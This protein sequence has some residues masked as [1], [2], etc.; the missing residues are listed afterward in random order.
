MSITDD[1]LDDLIRGFMTEYGVSESTAILAASLAGTIALFEGE[2]P[3][4]REFTRAVALAAQQGE[5]WAKEFWQAALAKN[6]PGYRDT[7]QRALA[8]GRNPV[9]ELEQEHGLSAEGAAEAMALVRSQARIATAG[10][11]ER[12]APTARPYLADIHCPDGVVTVTVEPTATAASATVHTDDATGP[13]AD[14]ARNATVKLNGD[15]LTV[16][17]PKVKATVIGNMSFQQGGAVYQNVSFIGSG[18]TVNGMTIDANGNVTAGDFH[19]NGGVPSGTR[20]GPSLIEVDVIVPPG[21][22]VKMESYN[23]PLTV[24]GALAALDF[25]THNGNLAAGVVGRIQ[26]RGYNGDNVIDSVQEWADLE[27]YN[28]DSE[29]GSYSGGDAAIVTYNGNIRLTASRNA[30][31]RIEARTYNGD[32]S[33]RGVSG[34]QDLNVS[35]KTRN[36]DIH[37]S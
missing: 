3:G 20:S 19:F 24:Y 37:K 17:V 15:V 1:I 16:V 33:L 28:G 5:E 35:T 30:T 14:A 32:I 23:A 4:A 29:I 13:A 2:V 34:R 11:T 36:G 25:K 21:S 31:G 10:A 6:L 8:S 18:A 26:V 12:E 9:A 27:T 7:Y 22:G